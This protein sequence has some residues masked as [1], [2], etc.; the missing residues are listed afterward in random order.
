MS[1]AVRGIL[2]DMWDEEVALFDAEGRVTGHAP[3]SVVRRDNLTHAATATLVRDSAG[4][5][6]V[7]RR[8]ESKDVYPGRHDCWAGGVVLAGENVHDAACRELAEE[9]GVAGVPLRPLFRMWYADQHTRYLCHAFEARWDGPIT[10]Q[11]SE[12]AWGAWMSLA[13]LE[14]RLAD[15]SWPFVP[16]GRAVFERWRAGGDT[17]QAGW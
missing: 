8:T 3:R 6:Y 9:L 2:A 16:D 11:A 15:P 5:V 14:S 12:V 1:F 17:D 4:A 10:H 13:D 7:H